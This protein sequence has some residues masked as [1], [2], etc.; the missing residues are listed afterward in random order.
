[1]LKIVIVEDNAVEADA[2]N[3]CLQRWSDEA[4]E[5]IMVERFSSADKFLYNYG[6]GSDVCFMDIAMPGTDGMEAARKLRKIDSDVPL[7]FVTNLAQYAMC[8]YKVDAL[9]YFLKPVNY[10]DLKLRMERIRKKYKHDTTVH[11]TTVDGA[12]KVISLRDVL[13]I[14]S[15]DH[16]L[17]YRTEKET[18]FSREKT[19]KQAESEYSEKGFARCNVCY[20]VN[21]RY[22][23][24]VRDGVA[25][26][27][28]HELQISR[29]KRK[30]FL[31]A[32]AD[33]FLKN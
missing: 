9:D 1:M 33:S 27:G 18:F 21:L 11:L 31:Q 15:N 22:C 10:Y 2:L 32:L 24:E 3:E 26:V 30:Q 25:V 13:Y 6:G 4:G 12:Q 8:G 20:L 28:G 23:T 19:M 14:E 7:I 5:T 16:V 29:A 17:A